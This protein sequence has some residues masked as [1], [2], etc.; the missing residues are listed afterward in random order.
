MKAEEKDKIFQ[1][2]QTFLKI[3]PVVIWGSGATISFGM[4]SMDELNETLKISIPDFDATNDNLEIELGKEKYQV[5]MPKIR[6]VIWERVSLSD[7]I[8]LNDFIAG[9]ADKYNG[10]KKMIE[11]FIEA[12][13]KVLS[14]ITTN[15]DRVLEYSLSYYNKNYTDGFI[16]KNLSSFNSSLFGTKDIVNIIKVHG[17]LNWFDIDGDIRCFNGDFTN[18]SPIIIAPGKSKFQEAYKS[19]YRE[20]IQKADNAIMEA[21]SILV[22]GFGF[23]DEHLTPKIKAAIKKGIP[24]VL[25]TKK[26]S[27]S[28][29]VELKNAT[30]YV[31]IEEKD[32]DS[33]IFYKGNEIESQKEITIKGNYWSLINFLEIL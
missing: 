5:D 29:F 21:K 2:I 17:S 30:K 6:K 22:V 3:P 33:R 16:G 1:I 24:I 31:L 23:N 20:L 28:T 4:P 9:K 18:D 25:I 7:L 27:T 11:I 15:Y 13:P 10:I 19:P 14:I 8:V 26:I 32:S 12:H